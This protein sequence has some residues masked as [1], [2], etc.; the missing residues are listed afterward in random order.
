MMWDIHDSKLQR[1]FKSHTIKENDSLCLDS[2]SHFLFSFWC[3]CL[4]CHSLRRC[5]EL[6]TSAITVQDVEP[7]SCSLVDSASALASLIFV[8]SICT[9]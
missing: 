8:F 3:V 5:D 1:I 4:S 7:G 6:H 9:G 2:Y